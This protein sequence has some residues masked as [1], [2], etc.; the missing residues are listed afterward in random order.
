VRD[1]T[2]DDPGVKDKRLLI[3]EGDFSRTQ[4]AMAR[5]GNTLGP[6]LRKC[7]DGGDLRVATRNS[8]LKATQ[9]HVT[10]VVQST[11]F[12]LVQNLTK[13]DMLTHEDLLEKAHQIILQEVTLIRINSTGDNGRGKWI[14]SHRDGYL[15][16]RRGWQKHGSVDK[17]A[18]SDEAEL[19]SGWLRFKTALEAADLYYS[20]CVGWDKEPAFDLDVVKLRD[21]ITEEFGVSRW[22]RTVKAAL[23]IRDE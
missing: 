16:S 7:W 6:I 12:E 22:D 5:T 2:G 23:S 20:N 13:A 9:P 10:L 15:L 4:R 21:Y 17:L 19:L 3:F 11:A 8:P 1:S 18:L 14:L